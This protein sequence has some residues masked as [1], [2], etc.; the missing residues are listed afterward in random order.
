MTHLTNKGVHP[1]RRK[2]FAKWMQQNQV[3]ILHTS[4]NHGIM[5]GIESLSR[6]DS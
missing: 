3:G 1:K 5:R 2:N 6:N 4:L